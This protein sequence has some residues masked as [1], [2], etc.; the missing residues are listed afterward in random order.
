MVNEQY[1]KL[2]KITLGSQPFDCTMNHRAKLITNIGEHDVHILHDELIEA[3]PKAHSAFLPAGMDKVRLYSPD[4][5]AKVL[6]ASEH[7]S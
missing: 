1:F 2:D 5:Y 6:I 7:A 3:L 4:A